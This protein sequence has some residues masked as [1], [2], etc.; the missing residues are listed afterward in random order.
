MIVGT[1]L[2]D[3]K[4]AWWKREHERRCERTSSTIAA[5]ESEPS[6]RDAPDEPTP[7]P[8]AVDFESAGP[9]SVR[10]RRRR[11]WRA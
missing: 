4:H 8:E 5:G 10:S 11:C 6:T 1:A 2:R 9:R 7:H 3:L